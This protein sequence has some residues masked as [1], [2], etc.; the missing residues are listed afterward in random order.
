MK[1]KNEYRW[2]PFSKFVENKKNSEFGFHCD[3]WSQYFLFY[4]QIL[5]FS[6]SIFHFYCNFLLFG[7]IH[8]PIHLA[9]GSPAQNIFNQPLFVQNNTRFQQ[10][11]HFSLSF[12]AHY[13][14]QIGHYHLAPSH[15]FRNKS[16]ILRIQSFD[17]AWKKTASDQESV[18]SVI[19]RE[20]SRHFSRMK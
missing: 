16:K 3:P 20:S 13:E 12:P 17:F 7:T 14:Q 5:P 19:N 4:V 18:Y 11:I 6:K 9:V 1:R 2:S 15:T 10:I 8:G